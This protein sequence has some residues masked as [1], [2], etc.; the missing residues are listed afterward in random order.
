MEKIILIGSGGHGKTIADTIEK[1]QLYEIE[2]FIGE[3]EIGKV[4][5]KNYCIV[6]HDNDL[7]SIY[8]KGIKNAFICIG[9]L[10]KPSNRNKIYNELKRIGFNIPVI[11]DNTAIVADNIIIG[12]GTYIGRNAVINSESKIGKMCIINTSSVIEHECIIGDFSHISVGTVLCGQVNIGND[13]FIGANATVIQQVKVG[14]KVIVGAG[15]VILKDT[16]DNIVLVG[17]PARNI[18][19]GEI[20]QIE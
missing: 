14:N 1:L 3:E 17:A 13:S 20:Y 5:Y 2:G 15:S 16:T 18:C 6:G 8:N 10:G 12:E 9:F 11:Q 19:K 4:V 7:E